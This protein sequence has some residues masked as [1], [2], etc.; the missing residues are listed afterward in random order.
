MAGAPGTVI[1]HPNRDTGAARTMRVVVV[2]LLLVTATLVAVVTVGGWDALEG[3]KGLQIAFVVIDLLLAA[4]V[5]R[6]RRGV[7]P[8][9][10]ALAVVLG[11]FAGVAAPAWFARDAPGFTDP[12]LGEDVLGFLCGV[13]VPVQTVLAI[14]A[15]HAF[16][17]R[18]NVEL[19]RPARE[20][21]PATASGAAA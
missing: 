10:A 15:L 19:E 3:A 7:L 12:G 8:V 20:A 14:A 13:L 18:W 16:N 9:A 4:M 6:W 21:G 1:E 17:Q 2:A 5:W 11:I